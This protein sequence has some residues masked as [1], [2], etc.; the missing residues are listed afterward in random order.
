MCHECPL[1]E[2]CSWRG[3]GVDPSVGSA[4]VSVAQAKFAGSDRQARGRLIKQLGECAVPIHAAAEIMDR[5]AEI[6]LRLVDDL[7]SDG[8]IVRQNDELMLP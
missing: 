6:A 1:I 3:T 7:I 2:Q 4:G 8:L 5:S